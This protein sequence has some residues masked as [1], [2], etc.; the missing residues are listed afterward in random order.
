MFSLEVFSH[1]FY[2]CVRS[3]GRNIC[4]LTTTQVLL[5]Q[6]SKI[7]QRVWVLRQAGSL[8]RSTSVEADK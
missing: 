7:L 8:E 2:C 6:Q 5:T 3:T 1:K 4:I